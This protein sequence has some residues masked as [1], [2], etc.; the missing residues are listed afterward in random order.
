MTKEDDKA[1]LYRRIAGV[2]PRVV[3]ERMRVFGF[4]PAHRDLPPDPPDQASERT[5]IEKELLA[6]ARS[7]S[8][9]E[10]SI[11]KALRLERARRWEESKKRRLEKKKLREAR[12]AERRAA[13]RERKRGL[14]THVGESLSAGLQNAVSDAEKL[15]ATKLP[16]LHT[17]ADLAAALGIELGRLR[18]LTYHRAGAALVHYRR[19]SIP[20]KTGGMRGISAPKPSLAKA[21]RWVFERI[22]GQ[23]RVEPEAHGFVPSRSIVTNAAPHVGKRV[24]LNLDLEE[25]FPSVTWKRAKGLFMAIGYSEQVST[26]LA[27][28]TTE[29]PRVEVDLDG[30]H[31]HVAI[32]ARRL[33]QG[34]CTSPAITN[35]LCRAL[36]RR[37]AG[38][39]GSFGFVYTR[40]ADDLTFSSDSADKVGALLGFI[41]RIVADEGF[42]EHAKKTRIMRRG[43]RQEVTGVVVNEKPSVA[44]EEVRELRAILHNAGRHGFDSQNRKN[45]PAFVEHLRGR[46]AFVAMV[47]PGRA[48]KLRVLFEKALART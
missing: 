7:G 14:V 1:R 41:R 31:L 2:N 12:A 47:D 26:L 11:A 34:A 17:A 36:D 45:H 40:Y 3:L 20:K 37:L 21:Q 43:R 42:T 19:Y 38:L 8:L 44:R 33:P 18:W 46:I 5:A 39:A 32:G 48:E 23:L 30:R 29:P 25:F 24:V 27:S 13:W 15:A 35:V 16:V 4:W 22:V 9:D 28:L 10:A 6:L